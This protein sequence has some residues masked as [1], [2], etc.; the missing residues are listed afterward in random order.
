MRKGKLYRWIAINIT[1]LYDYNFKFF[2]CNKVKSIEIN[3]RGRK[4]TMPE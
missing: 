1:K 4:I 2:F 3:S